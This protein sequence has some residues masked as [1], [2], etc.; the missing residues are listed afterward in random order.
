MNL[1]RA[2]RL[3]TVLPWLLIVC[4][5]I[6]LLAAAII[7]IEKVE[8]LQNP[9]ATFLCDLNPV[10]S[11]GSVMSTDQSNA[12]G[13]PNPIIGLAAFPVIITTGVMMLAGAQLKRWY[14][15]GLQFGTIF[16]IG[17]IHWLFFQ[18]VYSINALCPYCMAV[19][20]VTITTFWYV[21][22][23]NIEKGY[24]KLPASLQSAGR[25]AR[26]HHMDILLLW[27]L[28]IAGLILNHFWYYYGPLLGF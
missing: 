18:S 28:I 19:W 25:F 3:Q 2:W 21:T 15:L 12:F 8:L 27:F 7:M 10:V 1:F 23:Y 13:F 9:N 20:V 24:I 16:G 14:W 26:R 11:C 5:T 6:G 22:L 17:F 4:G